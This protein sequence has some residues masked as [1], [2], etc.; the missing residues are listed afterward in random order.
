MPTTI[1]IKSSET[2]GS[3]PTAAQLAVGEL[4]VNLADAKI[5]SKNSSGTVVQV[6]GTTG[7]VFPSDL[8]LITDV[9]VSEYNFGLI[10]E[11]A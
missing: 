10:T 1:Q 6:S 7:L 9:V 2:A 8:G 4:A 5:F 3:I 11:A